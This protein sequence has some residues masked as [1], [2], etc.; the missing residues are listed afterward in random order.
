MSVEDSSRN[1][2][3]VLLII[4]SLILLS[5]LA[6]ILIKPTLEQP[7]NCTDEDIDICNMETMEKYASR[8]SGTNGDPYIIENLIFESDF[9]IELY[10]SEDPIAFIIQNCEFNSVLLKLISINNDYGGFSPFSKEVSILNNIFHNGSLFISASL[11]HSVQNNT[12]YGNS[13]GS[14][15]V[16]SY[17]EN[18]ID[19]SFESNKFK[20][21]VGSNLNE[22]PLIF[23]VFENNTINGVE[24]GFFEN[25]FNVSISNTYSLLF[26]YNSGLVNVEN[27]IISN[28]SI[29]ITIA[30]CENL[31]ITN[32]SISNCETAIYIRNSEHITVQNC[33][34]INNIVG[35]EHEYNSVFITVKFNQIINSTSY[36]II[37]D[38][39]F[40]T[41]TFNNFIDNAIGEFSQAY[42]I[43]LNNDW[44]YNYWSDWTSGD[45]LIDG[46]GP[47]FEKDRHPL[48]TPIDF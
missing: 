40:C 17:V 31:T 26:V 11:I 6:I 9:T 29:G 22:S 14:E 37:S 30:Y 42:D 39:F 25:M 38:S 16:D 13:D 5:G 41:V 21:R 23:N 8:G 45:Y 28:S 7:V 43:G 46:Y 4:G 44:E 48:T 15:I 33:T 1:S 34:L 20:I 12:F 47:V 19:N 32:S 10:W 35:I 18:F 3:I 2:I 36:A 27:Q 24:I